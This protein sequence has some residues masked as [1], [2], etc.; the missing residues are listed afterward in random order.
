MG[1]REHGGNP[2]G[3]RGMLDFSANLNPLGLPPKAKE[4][5]AASIDTWSA[6]PDPHASALTKAL[7][8]AEGVPARWIQLGPGAADL[9]FRVALGLRP[10][11]ALTL[12]PTFSEYGA[13]L[14]AA[15][16]RVDYH[17]LQAEAGFALDG[18]LLPHLEEGFDLVI[19]CNP[20]NPTGRTADPSLL[21][22]I[23]VRCRELGA[24]LLVDECFN[25]FL[26]RPEAHTLKPLLGQFPN[27]LLLKAF[28]KLYAMAGLRLGYLFCADRALLER[29]EACSPSW[30]IS[31]PAQAAGLAALEDTGYLEES[32][33]L[34][35][36][37]R[38][39]LQQQLERLG[40]AVLGGEANY[41]FFR[42]DQ[43]APLAPRMERQGVLIRSCENYRGLSAHYNRVAVR[44]RP[45]NERLLQALERALG[46]AG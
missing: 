39:W 7:A 19:L 16:C 41:L 22:R 5:L 26:D 23:L 28:T 10:R 32:L 33:A 18:S 1:P 38:P 29:L 17:P 8:A 20:N 14:E 44:T 35:R 37:E 3:L 12:A 36:R 46:E 6:Y 45:E 42:C 43:P 34:I 30:S 40:L 4:A 27:L 24:L 13:A 21:R 25:P 9:I 31:A 2:K 11:R 15:G